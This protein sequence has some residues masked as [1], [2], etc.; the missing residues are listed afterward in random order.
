MFL[1]HLAH[2]FI[3]E[4]RWWALP[5]EERTDTDLWCRLC[6]RME[7]KKMPRIKSKVQLMGLYWW[8]AGRKRAKLLLPAKNV[9]VGT[10]VLH[11]GLCLWR[12]QNHTR[13]P[14]MTLMNVEYGF[15][16]S[17][18]LIQNISTHSLVYQTWKY[19][20]WLWFCLYGLCR[21]LSDFSVGALLGG[22][23]PLRA[24]FHFLCT[25][26]QTKRGFH[27]NQEHYPYMQVATEPHSLQFSAPCQTSY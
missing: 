10:K 15:L 17:K 3:L 6:G 19:L 1:A 24:G 13:R 12:G 5:P 11:W 20:H 21:A 23:L 25:C 2:F 9:Q 18:M 16:L 7:G 14:S 8:F 27:F 4:N 22:N 26:T